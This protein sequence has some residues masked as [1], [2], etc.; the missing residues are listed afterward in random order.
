MKGKPRRQGPAQVMGFCSSQSRAVSQ[1]CM[2]LQLTASSSRKPPRLIQELEILLQQ[3]NKGRSSHTQY[4]PLLCQG[5]ICLWPD[6]AIP[7]PKFTLLSWATRTGKV[8]TGCGLCQS[9]MV[10]VQGKSA[11]TLSSPPLHSIFPL[12]THQLSHS[13]RTMCFS[14]LLEEG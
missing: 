11:C 12:F 5:G 3:L 9:L 6:G 14:N 2:C 8:P 4:F 13:S 7:A 10:E 1:G